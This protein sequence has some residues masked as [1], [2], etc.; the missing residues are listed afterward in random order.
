M[1]END[2]HLLV[3]ILYADQWHESRVLFFSRELMNAEKILQSDV[4][5]NNYGS[6]DRNRLYV[7]LENARNSLYGAFDELDE[8]RRKREEHLLSIDDSVPHEI[9]HEDRD[10]EDS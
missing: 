3:K 7:R 2:P 1:P 8:Y 5:S 9:V 6:A 4:Y 10:E